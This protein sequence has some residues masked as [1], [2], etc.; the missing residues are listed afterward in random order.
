M[1]MAA[2]EAANIDPATVD[3]RAVLAQIASDVAAPSA[4]R[5]TACRLLIEDE[6]RAANK[7]EW[8]AQFPKAV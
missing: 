6:I 8:E 1:R 4:A 3:P 2:R 5:V 7:A